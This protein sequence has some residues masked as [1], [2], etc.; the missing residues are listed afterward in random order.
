MYPLET[1]PFTP[2]FSHDVC[3]V[4]ISTVQMEKLRVK[5]GQ[6]AESTGEMKC[7]VA[8]KPLGDFTRPGQLRTVPGSFASPQPEG[9]YSSV[10]LP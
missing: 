7:E 2:G 1:N 10:W 3:L 4:I 6:C 9:K 8:L 5:T